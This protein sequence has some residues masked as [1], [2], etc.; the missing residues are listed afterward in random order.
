VAAHAS[1]LSL[2]ADELQSLMADHVAM[3]IEADSLAR[4]VN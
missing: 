3:E 1:N 4:G 2:P